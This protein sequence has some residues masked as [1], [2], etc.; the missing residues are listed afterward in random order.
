MFE[1]IRDRLL[2][3]FRSGKYAQLPPADLENLYGVSS[4]F[5][6]L[7]ESRLGQLEYYTLLELHFFLCLLTLRD[8]EA[9]SALDR[10]GD[11]FEARSSEKLT[12]LRSYY[13]QVLGKK[14]A[15]EYLDKASA[16]LIKSPVDLTSKPVSRDPKSLRLVEKRKVALKSSSPTEYIENLLQYVDDSPLDYETWMELAEQY[17]DLGEYE[18]AY[19]CVQEVLVGAPG[20]YV[21]WCR[22]GEICRKIY[23]KDARSK[24]VLKQAQRSFLRAI[25]LCELHARSWCGLLVT[26]RDLKQTEIENLARTRLNQLVK[27]SATNQSDL[28]RISEFLSLIN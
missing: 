28:D 11:K 12:V 2:L 20:A 5:L 7:N 15:L 18:K 17:V 24:D 21:V 3:V 27:D 22:A 13:I 9:K 4:V 14:D 26:A 6:R 25:E 16:P 1:E 19:E 10:F 8:N 23:D